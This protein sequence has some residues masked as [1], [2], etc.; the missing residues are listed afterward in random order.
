MGGGKEFVEGVTPAVAEVLGE[1]VSGIATGAAD[2]A[3]GQALDALLPRL[4][5][6]LRKLQDPAALPENHDLLKTLKKAKLT[7]IKTVVCE[8][9]RS[10]DY[11]TDESPFLYAVAQWADRRLSEDDSARVDPRH[12]G[13]PEDLKPAP[14]E[15]GPRVAS[16][17]RGLRLYVRSFF[18]PDGQTPEAADA[19]TEADRIGVFYLE[20]FFLSDQ[21]VEAAAV[22]ADGEAQGGQDLLL[23]LE[24][25]ICALAFAEAVSAISDDQTAVD[26][27]QPAPKAFRTRFFQTDTGFFA[28][29]R[30]LLRQELVTNEAFRAKVSVFIGAAT[31][32][33]LRE[34]ARSFDS[35]L[36]EMR[37]RLTAVLESF[38]GMKAVFERGLAH[39]DA[40]LVL[41][42]AADLLAISTENRDALNRL[43]AAITGGPSLDRLAEEAS[44]YS[45]RNALAF[46]FSQRLTP[47]VGRQKEQARLQAFLDNPDSFRWWQVAGEAGQGKSRLAL[48]LVRSALRQGWRAGF[49]RPFDQAELERLRV[50]EPQR[51]T[52]IVIDYVAAPE[53]AERLG[54]TI[55]WLGRDRLDSSGKPRQ[56]FPK[57]RLLALER[58]PY[59]V[60]R[61][62]QGDQ[63][64]D[65][66]PS[67]ANWHQTLF[68]ERQGQRALRA[69]GA[70][71]DA[72]ALILN[73]LQSD[74]LTDIAQAW[75]LQTRRREL[76]A[77]ELAEVAVFLGLKTE[78]QPDGET[79]GEEQ[80]L[81]RKGAPRPLFAMLASEA[82][83]L[84]ER[85]S[86]RE[87]DPLA[88][89]LRVTLEREQKELFGKDYL[90]VTAEQQD[91]ALLANMVD[92]LKLDDLYK[93]PPDR[94]AYYPDSNTDICTALLLLGR[95]VA[96]E[97]VASLN[98][99]PA[100][101][102]DLTA[103]FQ[104]LNAFQSPRQTTGST[105]RQHRSMTAR[106][107][108]L[109]EDAWRLKPQ[110]MWAF[111]NRM[112]EDFPSSPVTARFVRVL[113][114]KCLFIPWSFLA[115]NAI[116]RLSG[117]VGLETAQTLYQQVEALANEYDQPALREQQA[118][119]GFNLMSDFREAGELDT[120]QAVYRQIKTL[121]DKHD[122]PALREQQAK[123]AVNLIIDFGNAGDLE[124]TRG[125]YE[126]IK[127]LADT[128]DEPA[129]R[130]ARA[131]A[132]FNLIIDFISAGDLK[133]ARRLYE[134]IKALADTHDEPGLR[135]EQAQA[136]INLIID[137]GNAGDLDTAQGLYEEIKAHADT[138]D[139][140]ALTEQQAKAGFNLMNVFGNCGDLKTARVLYEEIK[141]LA[142]MHDEP[143]LREQ[144]AKAG[145]NLII[146][147]A[148]A[149]D[150][151]TAW[152]LYEEIKALA[153]THDEP[154]LREEHAQA[155]INL[156][157][158]F[159]NAGDLVTA[160]SLYEEI[161]ALAAAQDEPAPR[162]AQAIAGFNLMN[163]FRKAGDLKAAR[164]LYKEI[165]ALADTYDEPA[166]REEQAKAAINLIIDF[167]NTGDLN[168]AR[169]LY[170]EIK[171]LAETHNDPALREEQAQAAVSLIIDF[172]NAG[173]LK[174]AR[175]L[176]EEIKALADSHD[177]QALRE[178]QAK[179]AV[180]LIVDYGNAGGLKTTQM[181]YQ[182]I[183]ALAYRHDEPALREA[184]AVAAFNLMH[185]FRKAGD[186]KTARRLYEEIKALADSHDEP[187]FREE[188][189]RAAVNLII[190]FGNAGDL[191][192]AQ[193]LYQQ[194]EV[195]TCRVRVPLLVIMY[196]VAKEIRDGIT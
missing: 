116:A 1:L 80:R 44:D 143:P 108:A 47:F 163:A 3:L 172:G 83:L 168:T 78:N 32:S 175:D 85:A 38:R 142:D 157:I 182:E 13:Q 93:L 144:Q 16:G 35:G 124:T 176:Y 133:T 180:N 134:E 37:G 58:Q 10:L 141:A 188:Q 50:W 34:L 128:H 167:G 4:G 54:N 67:L 148:K 145:F 183:K 65:K 24:Q 98:T 26:W 96:E 61:S 161:K 104:V 152:G 89:V 119:A 88:R 138:H 192:T 70:A 74:D 2:V 162:E 76:S 57:I 90:P 5:Q 18:E 170:E 127:A 25:W 31:H 184:Q 150:L 102:P 106:Q 174:T 48:E 91:L 196:R 129:V 114:E 6:A 177:E 159:G 53:R 40:G 173:D 153:E 155:A 43:V 33:D 112:I 63:D 20:A 160:R 59:V 194:I 118:R 136:A 8:S 179:A 66:A 52:L 137:F 125:L 75:S 117:S 45:A 99:L 185:G 62:Q 97:T 92:G 22:L 195:W 7:A 14:D 156:I 122:Q 154:G 27:D 149:G 110:A 115:V 158:D 17:L 123:A 121:A 11:R 111:L 72:R 151:K 29:L 71:F 49:W 77:S 28:T 73:R 64:V 189:A 39:G 190:N 109:C 135:E 95:D 103:E 9:Q 42:D 15:L 193:I 36:E 164:G 82:V 12:L 87:E 186:L 147:F 181:L 140:P 165:K 51:D 139:E 120:A 94:Q 41:R 23:G 81:Q 84:G 132:G 86:K 19:F 69:E 30:V 46:R 21:R 56:G 126:E 146:D 166:L 178:E 169:D 101:Q 55:D 131:K 187:A 68:D 171:A 105:R 79:A 191:N 107:Q 60:P 130:E 100:R 113:P